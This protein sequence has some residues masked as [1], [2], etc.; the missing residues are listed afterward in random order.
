M[1]TIKTQI[2][3]TLK[4]SMRDKDMETVTV[5]RSLQAAIK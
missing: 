3:D 1:T 2:T 4:A 5:V